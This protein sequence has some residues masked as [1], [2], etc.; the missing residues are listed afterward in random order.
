MNNNLLQIRNF[1]VRL[2]NGQTINEPIE[3]IQQLYDII[4]TYGRCI[5]AKISFYFYDNQRYFHNL[6]LRNSDEYIN[7]IFIIEF[8]HDYNNSQYIELS[9]Q[10]KYNDYQSIINILQNNNLDIILLPFIINPFNS[11]IPI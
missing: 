10:E 7:N 8:Y 2:T 4:N 6:I 5:I 3:N 11:I 9:H 1:Q